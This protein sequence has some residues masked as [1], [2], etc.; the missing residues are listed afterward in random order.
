[1]PVSR[2]T[3][4]VD[5]LRILEGLYVLVLEVILVLSAMVYIV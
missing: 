2:V 1:M 3:M 4:V 5:V